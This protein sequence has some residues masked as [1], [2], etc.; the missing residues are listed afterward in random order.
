MIIDIL[1]PPCCSLQDDDFMRE[2]L[3]TKKIKHMDELEALNKPMGLHE[4]CRKGEVDVVA[5]ILSPEGKPELVNFVDEMGNPPLTLAIKG[6]HLN[7]VR[8]MLAACK[9]DPNA[10][11]IE[12][13][14]ALHEACL[15]GNKNIVTLLCNYG[16][17]PTAA[18]VYGE[19]PLH[20][21]SRQGDGDIV[22]CLILYGAHVDVFTL[23]G[24]Y[25]PLMFAA[26][27]GKGDAIKHL[28]DHGADPSLRNLHWQNAMMRAHMAGHDDA[29][30]RGPK[31]GRSGCSE[32]T[33]VY[34]L[35]LLK[36][37]TFPGAKRQQKYYTAFLHN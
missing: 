22:E 26:G 37:R 32:A 16:A 33:V 5:E 19:T 25:T 24:K 15:V 13:N 6:Q 18:N 30:E 27:A 2:A 8:Y 34:S 11:G 1:T 14:T 31:D 7:L 20:F 29:G 35:P 36:Q 9:A 10:L 28:L 23:K 17:E 21:A 12:G 3:M 4:A